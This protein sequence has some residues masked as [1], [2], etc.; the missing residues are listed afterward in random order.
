MCSAIKW[1]P[2]KPVVLTVCCGKAPQLVG[3]VTAASPLTWPRAPSNL[4]LFSSPASV[5]WREPPSQLPQT[6]SGCVGGKNMGTL[7][8]DPERVGVAQYLYRLL[9]LKESATFCKPTLLKLHLGN[10]GEGWIS[11][12]KP[13]ISGCSSCMAQVREQQ[14][15]PFQHDL[16]AEK[17]QAGEGGK[18]EPLLGQG[19]R[20]PSELCTLHRMLMHARTHT[21][22]HTHTHTHS[23]L[24][25]AFKLSPVG[26]HPWANLDHSK[27]PTPLC[28]DSA[29][30][31]LISLSSR[32]TLRTN[33]L[34]PKSL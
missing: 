21:R 22:A 30:R 29:R 16:C 3:L 12:N 31:H 20:S 18:A 17:S 8:R 1:A 26:S 14:R 2:N 13:W 7:R 10:W 27:T 6:W 5:G 32:W 24:S 11:H 19:A 9:I 23:C 28:P 33:F 25:W 34:P 4:R 15:G